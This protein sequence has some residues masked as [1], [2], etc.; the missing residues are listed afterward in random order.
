MRRDIRSDTNTDLPLGRA[1]VLYSSCGWQPER[2]PGILRSMRTVAG[3]LVLL[4]GGGACLWLGARLIR[5]VHADV[6]KVRDDPRAFSRWRMS[7]AAVAIASTLATIQQ[8]GVL[9]GLARPVLGLVIGGVA[10][11]WEHRR[12]RKRSG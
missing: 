4:V 3:V 5:S 2:R 12:H 11:L 7:M 1:D 6:L 10:T 8:F 9:A